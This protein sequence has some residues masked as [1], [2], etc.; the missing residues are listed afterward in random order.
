MTLIGAEPDLPDPSALQRRL[1][2][3]PSGRQVWVPITADDRL[4]ALKEIGRHKPRYEEFIKRRENGEPWERIARDA[5]CDA[6]TF[7]DAI[8]AAWAI[9]ETILN[10]MAAARA[11]LMV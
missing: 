4:A 6:E 3:T 2:V 8:N 11:K 1:A 9:Y 10:D 5:R 7:A